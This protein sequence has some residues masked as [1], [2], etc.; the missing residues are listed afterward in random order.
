LALLTVAD[1]AEVP[2]PRFLLADFV[3]EDGFNVLFGP[4]GIGK[5]FLALDWSLCISTGLPFY[6]QEAQRGSV[7][8]IAAEGATGLHPRIET[9]REARGVD[10]IE[11]LYV[12]PDAVN[13]W[14]D[15][16]A[17]LAKG[18][19]DL[20]DPPALIVVDTV[21]R[22][23][24]GGEENSAKDV[25]MFIDRLSAF[26]GRYEAGSLAV[27]HTGKT[28]ELERGSSAFRG[29][30]D[31][32]S[33]LKPDGAGL[34]LSC[35]K[36]KDSAMFEPWRMHLAEQGESCLIRLGTDSDRL[37]PAELRLI[38]TVHA[39]F[40]TDWTSATRVQQVSDVARSSVYAA[41]KSLCQRGF[42]DDRAVGKQRREYRVT[43]AGEEFVSNRLEPSGGTV[44][45][46]PSH[47]PTLRGETAEVGSA[48][49]PSVGTRTQSERGPR[50]SL[51]V[52]PRGRAGLGG[53]RDSRAIQGRQG[54]PRRRSAVSLP[55]PEP[56]LRKD[57]GHGGG[58]GCASPHPPA[59]VAAL[60]ARQ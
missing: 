57:L 8:Y 33:A 17:A 43:P 38:E 49:T 46:R 13:F 26:C 29:A 28:G 45:N 5:S 9:W 14:R 12:W 60:L 15:D 44:T 10:A 47:T 54:R 2:A 52:G 23:M 35:E 3:R 56:R 55:H 50:R 1:L 18:I 16:T 51:R 11:D 42:M 20:P 4:S 7:V 40:G 37:A 31:A 19:E 39:S 27:H 58:R 41:L 24:V 32:M 36:Q 25:G 21:A 22:C 6:G 53:R 30:A 48:A 59:G 34:R